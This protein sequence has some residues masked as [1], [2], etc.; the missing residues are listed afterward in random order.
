MMRI[1]SPGTTT[2]CWRPSQGSASAPPLPPSAPQLHFFP[3]SPL[4]SSS[5]TWVFVPCHP[6][7]GSSAAVAAY[8]PSLG[9]LRLPH[10]HRS[11]SLLSLSLSIC[12]LVKK[13]PLFQDL[14]PPP[15]FFSFPRCPLTI[16]MLPP[17]LLHLPFLPPHGPG[18][19]LNMTAIPLKH[20]GILLL[21]LLIIQAHQEKA[22]PWT[23]L[24]NTER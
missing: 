1:N 10:S 18:Y 8:H 23:N 6:L 20:R 5:L 14:L 2:F 24:S 9:L 15:H 17:F 3:P 7:M 22:A 21:L 12:A 16:S 19:G 11:A 13:N 4:P